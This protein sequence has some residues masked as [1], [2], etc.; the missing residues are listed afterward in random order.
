MVE[1]EAKTLGFYENRRRYPKGHP[2]HETFFVEKVDGAW[3]EEVKSAQK[4][5]IAELNHSGEKSPL[6]LN[7]ND[8]ADKKQTPL[9]QKKKD[10]LLLLATE[11]GIGENIDLLQLNR[12]QLIALIQEQAEQEIKTNQGEDVE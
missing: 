12:S 1:V 6:P 10:E 8:V 4:I 2:K 11:S 5:S 7:S 3:M 9:M